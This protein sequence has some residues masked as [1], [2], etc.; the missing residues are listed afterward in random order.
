MEDRLVLLALNAPEAV[1][2]A[3][4]VDAV[5]L[6]RPRV[7]LCNAARILSRNRPEQ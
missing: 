4:V 6:R 7:A 3:H 2:A 5:H 1:H